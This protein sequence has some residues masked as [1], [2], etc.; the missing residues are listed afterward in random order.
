MYPRILQ[1]VAS[2]SFFLLGP[3]GTGKSN[4]LLRTFPEAN[5]IDLLDDEI[6]RLLVAGPERLR[7][8]INPKKDWVII[9]EVQRV[10]DL[11]NEVHRLIESTGH[12]FVLSGSS[13]RKLKRA[14]V[15]LLAGRAATC[16]MHPFTTVELGDDFNLTKALQFGMMPEVWDSE[17]FKRY[18]Q[19]YVTTYLKEEVNKR[20]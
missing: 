3:R 7:T 1:P 20:G 4:W 14:G 17:D 19:G 8:L 5:Y 16:Y 6:Y 12:R 15:N 11:L 13:A 10:P 18:L 2:R 9:D